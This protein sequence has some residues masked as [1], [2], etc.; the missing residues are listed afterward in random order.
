[1]PR[2]SPKTFDGKYVYT[3]LDKIIPFFCKNNISPNL[4][5]ISSIPIIIAMYYAM[6]NHYYFATLVFVVLIRVIDC[7]DG[8]VAR[9][10]KKTSKMGSYLDTLVDILSFTTFIF[11]YIVSHSPDYSTRYIFISVFLTVSSV[12]LGFVDPGNHKIENSNVAWC[13]QNSVLFGILAWGLWL[14][15]S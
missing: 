7:L 9:Q 4:V 8:T 11:G 1:M 2:P 15:F 5:T 10:C 12:V 6:V 13:E 14:L 3:K